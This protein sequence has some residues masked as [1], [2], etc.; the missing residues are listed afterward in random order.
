[1]TKD[2]LFNNSNIL[3]NLHYEAVFDE[4]IPDPPKQIT[5]HGK[6]EAQPPYPSTPVPPSQGPSRAPSQ[7]PGLASRTANPDPSA[8]KSVSPFSVVPFPAPPKVPQVYD[9]QLF[10]EF[11]ERNPNVKFIYVQWLDYMATLRAR[12]IPIKEFSRMIRDGDRIGISQGNTGTLQNDAL[13]PVVN[14]T[15]QIYVEPD[16]RSLRLTHNKDPLPSATVLSYWRAESGHAVREC[17]RNNLETV[18]NTLQYTHSTTLLVGFEIEVTFLSRNANDASLPYSPLTKTHAWGTLTPEQ[19]LQLPFLSEIVMALEQ[20]GIEV[21]QFHAESGQGQYEFVLPPSPPL[22]AVDT[23]IQA[24]QVIAQIASLH[25]LRATLHPTPFEGMG[26]AAHAHISLHPPNSDMQFFVGGVLAHLPA[27]C[28]F[29][30]PE[31]D[32]YARVVDDHCTFTVSNGTSQTHTNV[33][34][35]DGRHMGMLGHSKPRNALTPRARRM[36]GSAL[37]R[38]VCKHVL[39]TFGNHRRRSPGSLFGSHRVPPV[40]CACQSFD[41]GRGG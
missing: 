17:P 39:C 6:S 5:F 2:I 18:I 28:A 32:S 14:A 1:M 25:G 40:G 10:D 20:M 27:I 16:L 37:R 9:S 29:S 22:L 15:G 31:N 41:A 36:L 26:T 7:G 35:R 4:T 23:L 21:Q 30:M 19:W 12:I 11:T 13:T 38:R 3:Y 33:T 8:P 34:L 24:R